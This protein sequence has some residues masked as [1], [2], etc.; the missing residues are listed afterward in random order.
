MGKTEIGGGEAEEAQMCGSEHGEEGAMQRKSSRNL[1]GAVPLKIKL[2]VHRVSKDGQ[3]GTTEELDS[4][5]SQSGEILVNRLF[6][7]NRNP[8]KALP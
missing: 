6:Q 1:E 4:F 5:Q 3:Q 2:C 7:R 8:R